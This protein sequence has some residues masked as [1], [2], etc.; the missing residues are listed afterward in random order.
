MSRL[1]VAQSRFEEARDITDALRHRLRNLRQE[2]RVADDVLFVMRKVRTST[3]ELLDAEA[4]EA[5]CWAGYSEARR[6]VTAAPRITPS[7]RQKAA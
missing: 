2:L 7:K 3:M 5:R 1:E 4:Y 6:H